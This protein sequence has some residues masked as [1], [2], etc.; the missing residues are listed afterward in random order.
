MISIGEI[1]KE[2][3]KLKYIATKYFRLDGL[4]QLLIVNTY[5]LTFLDFH[6]DNI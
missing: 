6:S 5:Q 3:R 4:Q 2:N 1:A